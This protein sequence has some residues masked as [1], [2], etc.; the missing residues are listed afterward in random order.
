M[1]KKFR[2]AWRFI[3]LNEKDEILLVKQKNNWA[4]PG[5]GIDFWE[6]LI[7][8]IARESKEELW[9]EAQMDKIIFMQDF[10]SCKNEK[11]KHHF[12]VFC[13]IKNNKDFENVIKTY[14]NSSHSYELRDAKW[15]SIDNFPENF[16]PIKLKEVLKNFLKDKNNFCVK[17]HSA[18]NL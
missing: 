15:F 9:I 7:S 8:T 6:D 10:I 16:L 17:Y 14:K 12:E 5:G 11:L 2:L 3:I 1:K 13:T 18:I 4:I